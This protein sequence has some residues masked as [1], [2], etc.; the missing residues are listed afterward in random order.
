MAVPENGAIRMP[1]YALSGIGENAA[2]N[3]ADCIKNGD[4][5]SIE[6]L[7]EQSGVSKTVFET[8]ENMGAFAD[9]P[10]TAQL[11]LF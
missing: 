2:Q 6:E 8:L 1:F 11:S 4:F 7:K 9:L 3:L 5:I 10:K